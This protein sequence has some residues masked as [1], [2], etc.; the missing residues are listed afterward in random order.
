MPALQTRTSIRPFSVHH[1]RG[2]RVDLLGVG[3]LHLDDLGGVALGLHR[4]L[5]LRSHLG[6]A[7][8]DIDMGAGLRQRLDAG[9]A[10][11]LAAAGDDRDAAL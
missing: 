2:G 10:D 1:P 8:R 9:E 11:A 7:V 6:I 4:R 5:A 3:D